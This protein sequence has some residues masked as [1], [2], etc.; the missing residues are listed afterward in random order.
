MD[1]IRKSAWKPIHLVQSLNSIHIQGIILEEK[2]YDVFTSSH[3]INN[4][5]I[6]YIVCF[7]NFYLF[8]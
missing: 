8:I 4:K 5:N 7:L 1:E 2:I 6:L 3:V